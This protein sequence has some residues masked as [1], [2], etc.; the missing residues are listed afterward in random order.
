MAEEETI[1]RSLA[2]LK[3]LT[4]LTLVLSGESRPDAD[5][6]E[7]LAMLTA[8]YRE[9]YDRANFI[10]NL[11]YGNVQ[12]TDVYAAASRF[13][14]PEAGRRVLYVI[15]CDEGRSEMAGQF[16]KALFLK[17]SGDISAVLDE[18][19]A[20]L[21]RS[22][23][24][25]ED[26]SDELTLAHTIVDMLNTEAMIKVRVGYGRET[27]SLKS[28]PEAFREAVMSLEIGRIFYSSET[29][30]YYSRLGIGRLIYDLPEESGRLFLKELFGEGSPDDLDDETLS[31]IDAFFENNLNIA[32]TARR[33]Y[34]HRNTLVY[35][36]EKLRQATGLDL[37]IF[38]DAIAMKLA[39][40]I[41]SRLNRHSQS[42]SAKL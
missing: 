1:S 22:R 23:K 4:G 17:E 2:E 32:E 28:M 36:L 40:M 25:G 42:P 34:V 8:A 26:E 11:L 14:I 24:R 29:V 38:D 31:I 5:T 10:R 6:A 35:R 9:K 3:R 41:N 21:I 12:D 37:R 30:L 20:V 15:E 13:H 27:G 33:L 39:L 18:K 7:R 16:L 19:R